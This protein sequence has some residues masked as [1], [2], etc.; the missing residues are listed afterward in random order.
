M[1]RGLFIFGISLILISF[2]SAGWFSDF[3]NGNEI[4]GYAIAEDCEN[5]AA[6]YHFD[7]NANDAS[8]NSNDGTPNGVTSVTGKVGDAYSFDG[9]GSDIIN[10]GSDSSLDDLGPM[11]LSMWVYLDS[12][13]SNDRI[14]TKG[15][16]GSNGWALF[17][18]SG[19][20]KRLTFLNDWSGGMWL[21]VGVIRFQQGNGPM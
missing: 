21:L 8:D 7:G 3:F 15:V 9:G 5:V 4:T 19:S 12:Y 20:S 10:F 6:L 16:A 18:G 1:R 17:V 14:I 11:S 2:V 13:V